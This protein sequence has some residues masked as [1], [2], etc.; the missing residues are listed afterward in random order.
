MRLFRCALVV[1]ASLA[2]G[3]TIAGKAP[4][5]SCAQ[6]APPARRLSAPWQL[7]LKPLVL[8]LAFRIS[9]SSGLSRPQTGSQ[10]SGT[11]DMPG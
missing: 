5:A 1:A 3:L 2:L 8:R 11:L 7:S 10:A 6:A 9:A 4:A